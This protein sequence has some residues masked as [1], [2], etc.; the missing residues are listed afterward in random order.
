M[1]TCYE[2]VTAANNQ[3]EAMIALARALDERLDE[4]EGLILQRP[5][6]WTSP[7]SDATPGETRA[8]TD[9]FLAATA[10]LVQQPFAELD[11]LANL[12]DQLAVETDPEERTAIE[13]RIRLLTDGGGIVEPAV[14]EGRVMQEVDDGQ[15]VIPAPDE[16]RRE[17]RYRLMTGLDL[18]KFVTQPHD[19]RGVLEDAF[20]TG[21][22]VWLYNFDRV[23]MKSMPRAVLTKMI[24]ED[25]ALDSPKT[26]RAM[27]RDLL[28][29]DAT[30]SQQHAMGVA[31]ESQE[32]RDADA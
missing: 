9:G 8:A 13:A 5:D 29:F 23:G 30:T 22:P 14:P 4:L 6:D 16:T 17:Q 10:E 21:G 25:V 15:F 20:M 24:D 7:W 31:V 12:R 19:G 3:R 18:T 1:Q 27:G 32:A 2:A 28:K 26:A 11:R